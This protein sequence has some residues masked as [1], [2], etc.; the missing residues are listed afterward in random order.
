MVGAA[1]AQGAAGQDGAR[2]PQ[3]AQGSQGIAGDDGPQGSQGDQG[4]QGQQGAAGVQGARGPEG[5]AG[6]AGLVA[7]AVESVVQFGDPGLTGSA[8]RILL[9]NAITLNAGETARFAVSG[10]HQVAVYAVDV[11]ATR[12][13]VLDNPNSYFDTSVNDVVHESD[14]G[15]PTGRI[16][17]G[18]SPRD[19]ETDVVDRSAAL[20]TD[21]TVQSPGK[22]LVICAIRSHFLGGMFGFIDVPEE[23]AGLTGVALGSVGSPADVTV[24][25][26]DPRFSGRDGENRNLV[27]SGTA[28]SPGQSVQFNVS[29]FHQ[30]AVY[31]VAD[32]TTRDAVTAD[33]NTF[34]DTT[35]NSPVSE[36]YIGDAT[37][38]VALGPSPSMFDTDAVNRNDSLGMRVTLSE[39]GRYLVICAVRGHFLDDRPEA[40]GGMFG[41][42]DVS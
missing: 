19:F 1:G 22:Y 18:A 33:P 16:A 24:R 25:F 15:D 30:I 26:G 13:D 38:R 35:I 37:G 3:G 42:I 36:S 29:G 12:Q 27:P 21:V 31:Q 39:P 23:P 41:F 5:P 40:N 8:S 6:A 28:V 14:L 4:P 9:P 20:T 17:L 32:G 11:A 34:L 7:D 10:F 2:G